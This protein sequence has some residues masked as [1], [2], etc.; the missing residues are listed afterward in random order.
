MPAIRKGEAAEKLALAV[1]AASSEDLVD[2]YAELFPEKAFPKPAAAKTLVGEIVSYIRTKIEP[3]EIVDLWNVVFPRDR[4]V[5][6]NEL[7]EVVVYNQEEPW[8]AER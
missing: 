8:F 3:E 2:I 4:N 5:Y 6:Y 7:D 1:E